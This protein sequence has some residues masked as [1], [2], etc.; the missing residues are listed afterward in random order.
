MGFM[1]IL[2]TITLGMPVHL[3]LLLL[4]QPGEEQDDDGAVIEQE[5]DQ[6][7]IATNSSR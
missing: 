4:H 7:K 3:H 2:D 5:V 6:A 1:T